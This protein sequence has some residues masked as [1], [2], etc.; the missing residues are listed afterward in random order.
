MRA[1][2]TT[3]RQGGIVE[4]VAWKAL[5]DVEDTCRMVVLYWNMAS[6]VR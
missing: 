3:S 4:I 1:L 6:R 2:T 5:L